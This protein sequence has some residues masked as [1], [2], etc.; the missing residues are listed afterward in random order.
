VSDGIIVKIEHVRGVLFC[1]RGAKVWF[2]KHGLDFRHFLTVG[3]PIETIEAT[4]DAL[5]LLVAKAAR[6]EAEGN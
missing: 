3:Y 4:G 2:E 6:D 5:G 1:S